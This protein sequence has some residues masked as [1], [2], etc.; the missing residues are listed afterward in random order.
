M[1][2]KILTVFFI[3]LAACIFTGLPVHAALAAGSVLF[4]FYGRKQGSPAGELFKMAGRG[5]YTARN[6]VVVLLLV[7]VLTALWRA[8]GTIPALV[9][10]LVPWIQ[11]S[12]FLL[13]T[14]LLNSFLS[15]LTGTS[16]GTAATMGVICMSV[17]NT[18]G[19]A[20]YLTGGAILSGIFFGD[21]CSPVSS[22]ALLV[23]ELTGTDIY[24]NVIRMI[25][26]AVVPFVISC[27]LYLLLGLQD[28]GIV[29]AAWVTQLFEQNFTISPM[30]LLPAAVILV[31]S[32]LRVDVK[33]SMAAS[34]GTAFMLCLAM[35]HMPAASII[36]T[37]L[38]GY[39]AGDEELARM[40][41]GGG[42]CSMVS[43]VLVVC[44]AASYSGFFEGTDLLKGIQSGVEA[45][46]RRVTVFGSIVCTS[47]VS[48]MVACNQTLPILLT[49]QLCSKLEQDKQKMAIDLE[50]SAVILAA[51]I[52][53]SIAGSVPLA[54]VGAPIS[55]LIFAFFLYLIP[56]WRWMSQYLSRSSM[57]SGS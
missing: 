36:H 9:C 20:P 2:K 54:T 49:Y 35:Q 40:I 42:L 17:G 21:R 34:C 55:S 7:G 24:G 22:S 8:S 38:E 37:M 57:L 6:I 16:F 48:A 3:I 23:C 39:H 41:D 18:M 33:I 25:K 14:F 29:D 32:F 51:L 46:S 27:L 26:T 11:P 43:V 52:P 10:Y 47:V 5:V 50:D 4:F 13:M 19:T 31:L 45:L 56:M 30:A 53:W 1:E 12:V 28:R 44:L 15:V